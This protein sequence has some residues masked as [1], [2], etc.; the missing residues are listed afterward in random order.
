MDVEFSQEQLMLKDTAR[1]LIRK[2]FPEETIREMCMAGA[3]LA[4][5]EAKLAALGVSGICFPE[6][7]GGEELKMTDVAVVI[8]ALSR[9]SID[10]GMACG[11]NLAGGI[12]L[13]RYGTE[14]QRRTWLT[15]LISGK[16]SACFGSS[17]PFAFGGIPPAIVKNASEATVEIHMKHI[18]C[19]NK[20]VRTGLLFLPVKM[21]GR[22][23]LAL[24]PLKAL[25]SG[26]VV[27]MVGRKLL[28]LRM[29]PQQIIRCDKTQILNPQTALI[30]AVTNYLKFFN[31]MSIV[32]NM[33]TVVDKTIQYAKARK[34][35]G[36]AIGT[37]QAIAHMIVDAKIGLDSSTLYGYWL[38]WQLEK[39]NSDASKLNSAVNMA[40]M[41]VSQ[42]FANAVNTAI[43]VMGGYGYMDESHIE[44]YARDARMTTFY[45]EDSYAQKM[46][47]ADDFAFEMF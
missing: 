17:E 15:K 28:G 45:A 41:F 30:P 42:S 2:E 5:F 16:A 3:G 29:Y 44:R 34:Q 33:Q 32:G 36:Q 25:K 4:E 20:D 10:M 24:I 47:V 22:T 23:T 26:Q 14:A 8:E 35:F 39:Q 1:V 18:Y 21:N 13:L 19:E 12:A 9:F 38:A 6:R 11:V 46:M 7:Y 31:V 37:F 40:N 27:E 43:Q